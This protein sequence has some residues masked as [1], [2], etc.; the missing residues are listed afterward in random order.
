MRQV[1]SDCEQI[2]TDGYDIL[3]EFIDRTTCDRLREESIRLLKTGEMRRGGLRGVLRDS[4]VFREFVGAK[5][6]CGFMEMFLG[7]GCRVVRSILFDKTPE[8]N[9]LVPWHQDTTIAVKSKM[10]VAGFG[11]WSV[12][13]DVQHVRP[14]ANV[15]EQMLT[16]RVHLDD[17][18]AE[19]GPLLVVPKS[20][21]G[22]ILSDGAI[23][24][25]TC[26]RHAVECST[27]SGGAVLMRP[28]ALHASRR[29]KRP[30]HRRILHLEYASKDALTRGLEWAEF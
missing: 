18:G 11:P 7:A 5:T 26:D 30:E 10:E 29:A 13:D 20:H 12:K 28:L 21:L 14:P 27:D 17:S 9:W 4:E 1:K 25:E 3:P 15:L 22:G 16:L 23:D 2:L 8:S 6:T 24:S 19:N